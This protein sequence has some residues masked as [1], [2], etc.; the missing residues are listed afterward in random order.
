VSI[1]AYLSLSTIK[2][3]FVT[4]SYALKAEELQ[5]EVTNGLGSEFSNTLK[6]RR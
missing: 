5:Y 6:R 1:H 4:I 2:K 3:L